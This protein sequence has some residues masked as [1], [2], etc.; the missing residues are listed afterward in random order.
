VYYGE[1]LVLDIY[2]LKGIFCNV[3]VVRNDKRYSFAYITYLVKRK[4]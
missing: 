3:A 1:G 4:G 2:K